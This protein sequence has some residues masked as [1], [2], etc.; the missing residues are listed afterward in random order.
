MSLK[1]YVIAG[2][3]L[4]GLSAPL[5]AQNSTDQV[6]YRTFL[7]ELKSVDDEMQST[8]NTLFNQRDFFNL[9]DFCAEGKKFLV[10]VD[11]RYPK[12]LDDLMTELDGMLSDHLGKRKVISVEQIHFA[13]KNSY[14]P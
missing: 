12:R 1:K 11:S 9:E 4:F 3:L 10:S 5:A 7:I 2:A 13:E 8:L 14:C 6:Y